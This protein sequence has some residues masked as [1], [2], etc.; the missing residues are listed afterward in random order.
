[1]T[2]LAAKVSAVKRRSDVNWKVCSATV[3]QLLLTSDSIAYAH[4]AGQVQP[5]GH[6]RRSQEAHC[7]SDGYNTG[8]GEWIKGPEMQ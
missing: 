1:M 7:R 3:Y 6:G 4:S 8:E 2:G 5:R